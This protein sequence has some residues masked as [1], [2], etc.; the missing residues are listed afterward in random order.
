[1]KLNYFTSEYA[2]K[3]HDKIIAISGGFEGVKIFGNLDS[4]LFH[5]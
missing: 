4:P 5:I 2:I 1:M 3:I